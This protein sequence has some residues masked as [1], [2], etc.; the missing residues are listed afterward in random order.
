[1]KLRKLVRFT[2]VKQPYNNMWYVPAKIGED[3]NMLALNTNM[4][5]VNANMGVVTAKIGEDYPMFNIKHWHGGR[6]H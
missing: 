6:K 2:Y 3:S 1:M 4:G 5:V